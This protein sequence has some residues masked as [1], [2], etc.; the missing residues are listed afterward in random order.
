MLARANDAA[1][2]L[3]VALVRAHAEAPE[4]VTG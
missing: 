2:R 3:V 1:D 4:V